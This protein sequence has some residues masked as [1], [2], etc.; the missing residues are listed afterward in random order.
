M[1]S[2]VF[3]SLWSLS[4]RA[5]LMLLALGVLVAG[6]ALAAVQSRRLPY[7][8]WCADASPAARDRGISAPT[9]H[10]HEHVHEPM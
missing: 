4:E 6:L 1:A 10:A 5:W 2:P 3:T 7:E 9:P 8:C